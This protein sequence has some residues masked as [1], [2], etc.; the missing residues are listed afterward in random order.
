MRWK[1]SVAASKWGV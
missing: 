1:N